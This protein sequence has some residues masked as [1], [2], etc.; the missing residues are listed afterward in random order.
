MVIYSEPL[1]ILET[2]NCAILNINTSSP[3]VPYS[4][5]VYNIS[6]DP[7]DSIPQELPLNQRFQGDVENCGSDMEQPG[8]LP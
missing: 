3:D 8:S 5:E 6:E 4:P 2:D 7:R 1:E